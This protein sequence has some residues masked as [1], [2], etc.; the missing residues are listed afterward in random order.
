LI[1]TSHRHQFGNKYEES[2]LQIIG[3]KGAI[4][5]TFDVHPKSFTPTFEY[6]I[7]GET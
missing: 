7:I 1:H 3:S 6:F 5:C 2:Y 4:R